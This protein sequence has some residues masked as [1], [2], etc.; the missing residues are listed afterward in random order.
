MSTSPVTIN[1]KATWYPQLNGLKLPQALTASITQAYALIYSLRDAVQ[2]VQQTQASS[3]AAAIA[4][5]KLLANLPT[6]P[7]VLIPDCQVT[8]PAAGDYLITA[9]IAVSINTDSGST[10][11]FTML[12]NGKVVHPGMQMRG[13]N[14]S[15]LMATGQW[16]VTASSGQMA[17]MFAQSD[18]LG[19]GTSVVTTNG[20]SISAAWVGAPGTAS[21]G[22]FQ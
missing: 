22:P 20:T 10:L 1:A 16:I 9:N 12:F 13:Q 18:N 7:P 19:N 15:D 21:V 14:S 5:G 6:T 3:G 11:I 4:Y 2:H 17:Q 8:I